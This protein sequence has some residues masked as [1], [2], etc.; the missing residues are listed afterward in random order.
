MVYWNNQLQA[1]FEETKAA[2]GKLAPKSLRYYD[3]TRP[4][5][6][7]TDYS[8]CDIGF[9]AMQQYCQCVLQ[10]PSLCCKG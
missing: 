10:E 8:H 3:V 1:I 6:V 5:L 7:F 4:M 9:L 2:A